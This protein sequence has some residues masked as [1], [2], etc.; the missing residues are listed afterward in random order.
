MDH[1]PA[2]SGSVERDH[3]DVAVGDAFAG[4]HVLSMAQYS[5]EDL[6]L[7]FRTAD[8]LR[9]QPPGGEDDRPRLWYRTVDGMREQQPDVR[10]NRPLAG[11]LLMSA[12]FDTSTRTRLAHETAMIRLGGTV[13]GFAEPSVTRSGGSTKENDDDVLRMLDLYGDVVVVRHPETGWTSRAAQLAGDALLINAGDGVGEHPTQAMV[14]LYTLRERF[15]MIDGLRI[16]LVNDLRMRCVRSI[17]LGLRHYDCEVYAVSEQAKEALPVVQDGPPIILGDDPLE[18]VSSADVIY[19][20]PTVPAKVDGARIDP[21]QPEQ[22]TLNRRL[23][24]ER[25]N[26]HLT[27]LHP[28]PRKSEL[29]PDVDDTRFNGYWAQAA[30]GIT[31]RMALLKLM[32]GG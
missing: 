21:A 28:L 24:E 13:A 30:H 12:F 5:R 6:E 19:S 29:A 3:G 17:L 23:L 2:P 10:E 27:V 9:E 25:G 15:G 7:L 26:D 31:V 32:F 11:R 18:L 14:D 22:V 1:I 16:L 20:S 4:K 8:G